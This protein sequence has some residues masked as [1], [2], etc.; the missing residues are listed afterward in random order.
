MPPLAGCL[1][2]LSA[3]LA[4]CLP[5]PSAS[6]CR[7]PPLAECLPLC[8]CLPLLGASPCWAPPLAGCLPPLAECLPLLSAS[9]C[10]HS[11]FDLSQA[12]SEYLR[13]SA[14]SNML[15]DTVHD[16]VSLHSQSVQWLSW[17][18]CQ[19]FN[20]ISANAP[21]QQRVQCQQVTRSATPPLLA[22]LMLYVQ[23]AGGQGSRTAQIRVHCA[24]NRFT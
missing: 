18:Y 16:L 5:L 17:F 8:A 6:P 19:V 4:E 11:G 3:S 14:F 20:S 10:V 13:F 22:V 12:T 21:G 24:D 2:L 9:P 1:P 7:V 23:E 15:P